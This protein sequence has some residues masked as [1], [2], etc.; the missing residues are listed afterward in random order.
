M[1]GA[2]AGLHSVVA[3]LVRNSESVFHGFLDNQGMYKRLSKA[4]G[5]SRRELQRERQGG[6]YIRE[7]RALMRKYNK[8]GNERI[9]WH[10]LKAHTRRGGPV[11]ERHHECDARAGEMTESEGIQQQRFVLWDWEVVVVRENGERMEGDPRQAIRSRVAAQYWES[12]GESATKANVEAMRKWQSRMVAKIFKDKGHGWRKKELAAALGG[13]MGLHSEWSTDGECRICAHVCRHNLQVEAVGL[14]GVYKGKH[15]EGGVVCYRCKE[16]L[17]HVLGAQCNKVT[18]LLYT[19]T[20]GKLIK[21]LCKV[22]K[23]WEWDALRWTSDGG[24]EAQTQGMVTVTV[25]KT[26]EPGAKDKWEREGF[27]RQDECGRLVVDI[28]K[29]DKANR[30]GEYSTEVEKTRTVRH[31]VY[32]GGVTELEVGGEGMELRRESSIGS[33]ICKILEAGGEREWDDIH[34][35]VMLA[36]TVRPPSGPVCEGLVRALTGLTAGGRLAVGKELLWGWSAGIPVMGTSPIWRNVASRAHC[37]DDSVRMIWK[38]ELTGE[39]KRGIYERCEEKGVEAHDIYIVPEGQLRAGTVGA[40]LKIEKLAIVETAKLGQGRKSPQQQ[41]S[42]GR[43]GGKK[44]YVMRGEVWFVG[45]AEAWE[46]LDW[47]SLRAYPPRSTGVQWCEVVLRQV[48][49]FRGEESEEVGEV[50]SGATETWRGDDGGRHVVRSTVALVAHEMLNVRGGAGKI[51]RLPGLGSRMAGGMADEMVK[52]CKEAGWEDAREKGLRIAQLGQDALANIK[53]VFKRE[54]MARKGERAD[55][56]VEEGEEEGAMFQPNV[57][58][59]YGKDK[60]R[61]VYKLPAE[62]KVRKVR[63]VRGTKLR[64]KQG[65]VVRVEKTKDSVVGYVADRPGRGGHSKWLEGKVGQ[66]LE[67]LETAAM[68]FKEKGECMMCGGEGV[69]DTGNGTLCAKCNKGVPSLTW[70]WQVEGF[71]LL[72][73]CAAEV[74]GAVWMRGHFTSRQAWRRWRVFLARETERGAWGDAEERWYRAMVTVTGSLPVGR[75]VWAQ[76]WEGKVACPQIYSML[77]DYWCDEGLSVKRPC[78]MRIGYRRMYSRWGGGS[79]L[80]RGIEEMGERGVEQWAAEGRWGPHK[81]K[82]GWVEALARAQKGRAELAERGAIARRKKARE[83]R[84]RTR[85]EHED[86][87]KSKR[88]AEQAEKAA[89]KLRASQGTRRRPVAYMVRGLADDAVANGRRGGGF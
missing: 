69:V 79:T 43:K 77:N 45:G 55:V 66:W 50:R 40:G 84:K 44:E 68:G 32:K 35:A 41:V 26:V 30:A 19:E 61:G 63:R 86:K 9:Q 46:K 88:A 34:R 42:K 28:G 17:L 53:C 14:G 29:M 49:E 73:W 64:D 52:R 16:T 75:G 51:V 24:V 20:R 36:A 6:L 71:L 39:D 89:K 58:T 3:S 60:S 85:R 4:H 70:G 80:E 67:V 25:T 13:K 87:E 8:P 62:I 57:I 81:W 65:K 1:I 37:K 83:D 76:R 72:S 23:P 22:A 7:V 21:D 27:T 11:Y 48:S 15:R 82:G 18:R 38:P 78:W 2:W 74:G 56:E 54:V 5:L 12:E 31:M 47:S 33:Y 10:W 59:M